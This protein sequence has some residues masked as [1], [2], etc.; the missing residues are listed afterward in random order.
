M[1]PPLPGVCNSIDPIRQSRRW[2][3]PLPLPP[4]PR[5]PP[6]TWRLRGRVAESGAIL[7]KG[8]PTPR[9]QK[10]IVSKPFLQKARILARGSGAGRG[11][12]GCHQTPNPRGGARYSVPGRSWPKYHW[13]EIK[14]VGKQPW[15]N[16]WVPLRV[17]LA[18][19]A[20]GRDALVW[21]GDSGDGVV[22]VPDRGRLGS[23]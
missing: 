2:R 8:Q 17:V 10:I 14:C 9:L 13:R 20:P 15:T 3:S 22:E 7:V 5:I 16:L 21:E 18:G 4:P 19:R 6:H 11:C 1:Q 23:L 12:E